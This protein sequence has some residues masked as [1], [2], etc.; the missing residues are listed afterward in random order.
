MDL[1]LVAKYSRSKGPD[2]ID[3]LM[4]R[5]T[6]RAVADIVSE[7]YNSS[8]STGIVPGKLKIA[9]ITPIFKQGDRHTMTNYRA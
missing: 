1:A 3:P 7:I 8:F 4:A 6:I 2:D 9:K 5:K